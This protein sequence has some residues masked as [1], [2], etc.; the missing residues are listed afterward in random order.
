M[1]C[2]LIIEKIHTNEFNGLEIKSSN[3]KAI[4]NQSEIIPELPAYQYSS[5]ILFPETRTRLIREVDTK[6]S[7]LALDDEIDVTELTDNNTSVDDDNINDDSGDSLVSKQQNYPNSMGLSFVV[8]K[9]SD[10]QNNLDLNISFIKSA[11]S[12]PSISPM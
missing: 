9:D 2:D 11:K 3:V 5:A 10:I 7:N 6:S 1:L 4:D 12:T 8:N